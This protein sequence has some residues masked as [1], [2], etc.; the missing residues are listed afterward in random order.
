MKR[1]G[2]KVSTLKDIIIFF[3]KKT[4]IFNLVPTYS[5][6]IIL[7]LTIPG[8]SC[9]NERSFSLMK[10]IKN[11]LRTTMGQERLNDIA[12]IST[13][14]DLA[15]DLDIDILLNKFIAINSS[16]KNAFASK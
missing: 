7:I 2:E 4:H 14:K 1:E 9:S 8:S 6:F 3:E 5:N 16:R 13:Y 15:R 10:R 12:L 11:Y